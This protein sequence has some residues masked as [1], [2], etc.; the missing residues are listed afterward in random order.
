MTPRIDPHVLAA[1]LRR[2][3]AANTPP[4]AATPDPWLGRLVDAGTAAIEDE[5]A[6]SNFTIH[7]PLPR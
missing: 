1:S 5:A 4:A 3:L 2:A 6:A 7:D